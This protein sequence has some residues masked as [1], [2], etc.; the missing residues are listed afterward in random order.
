M[1][2]MKKFQ[3]LLEK[4]F[5]FDAADLDFGVYRILNAKKDRLEKFIREDLKNRVEA[6]FAKHKEERLANIEQN[7]E[8]ATQKVIQGL[9]A[10][11]LPA[12]NNA[13]GSLAG[14]L[15]SRLEACPTKEEFKNTPLGR[16][17]LAIKEQKIEAQKIDEIKSQVFNDLFNFFFRFYAE[18]DFVPQYR[19]SIKGHK[20]AIPYNGEEVK[21]YWANKS[22]YYVKTGLLFR[23]YTFLTDPGKAYKI[24]FRL[25]LAHEELGSN[26]A[27]KE[28]FFVLDDKKPIEN[29]PSPI[30]IIVRFCYRELTAEE[31]KHYQVEGGSNTS[32]QEKINQKTVA[33]VL[34]KI[35]DVTLKGF[36][37]KEYKDEKPLLLYQLL[38]FTAKNTKDYFI[39]QNLKRFLSEQLDYF[40]KAEVL[41]LETLEKEKFLDKHI[42][43]AKVVQ[44]IG[45]DIIDFLAQIED[46]QK[47]LWEKKK[48]VLKTEYVI[49]CDRVPEEF[50]QEILQNEEQKREWVEMGFD[51]PETKEELK[52]KKL[53]IDTRYFTQEFKEKLLEKITEEA[54]LDELLDGLLIKSENWQALNLLMGKYREKI[55]TI[56]IDPPFN[57]GTNA[58][59]LYNVNYKDSSWISILENRLQLAR[60][61]LD[62]KGSI[63]VRCDYNGNMFVRLLLNYIFGE[64]N[65]RNE[66]VINKSIR[67]KTE[68]NKYPT[69]HDLFFYYSKNFENVYFKHITKTREKEEWRSIDTEGESWDIVPVELLHLFSPENLK[70]DEKGRA[71][72]RARIILGQEILPREG[73]RYPSQKT[74]NELERQNRI[75]LASSGNPQMLKPSEI[76]LTDNWSDIY[77][78][79]SNWDFQTENSEIT[80]KRVIESTSNTPSANADTPLK[81]GNRDIVMDF[82]LGSGTTTAVAHKLGRKWIGVEMGEHFW[83]VVLPRMKKVLAYDKSGV[84]KEKDVKEKYN[85]KTTGGFFKYH[86]LEQYEDAL[87]NIELTS[88]KQAELKLG[89]D[90]L[91]KYFLDYE[92]RGNPCLLNMEQLKNPFSYKLKVNLEEVGEPQEIMVDIPETF[93]YLLGL[94][95]KRMKVKYSPLSK[96]VAD[97]RSDGVS[98]KLPYNPNLKEKARELRKSGNLSEVLLWNKLKNRQMLGFDFTR[99]QIIGDYIV[100]FHCPKLNLVIEID[101]ESHDFKGAYDEKRDEF[102]KSLGLEVLHFKDIDVKKLLD[103]VLK[104]IEFWIKGNTPSADADTPLE[105]GNKYLFVLGEKESKDI[106]VV[107]RE[108]N[109]NWSDDDFKKDKEFIV[110]EIE[111][112]APHVVYVNGQSVLTPKLG[113][114]LIEVRY[115]EP[116]FKKLMG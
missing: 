17:Y 12:R 57:L 49:T 41:S 29:I 111:P 108:Y 1:D 11:A 13:G 23:D 47:R 109:D 93:N 15:S 59:F 94:K 91:L 60:I 50:Y 22:S 80:L 64:D 8:E 78:Y 96:G 66:I 37:T 38:R 71:I 98:K 107:W 113:K 20:Y 19:Y 10:Q 9:G 99:Q 62:D 76:Y 67:I 68:G 42:T 32:K 103:N 104:Q 26:K 112:W 33:E 21:L 74:I 110:K 28:R 53:P 100:D 34:S 54:N 97:R 82:F 63:F 101:G 58:D 79:S 72:S 18:G 114:H 45:E 56:Y 84:S 2:T 51:V 115:I 30:A 48:F 25:V 52:K 73:R 92:T 61:M 24:I 46:F 106:A 3:D 83:T 85:E 90:Y 16:E 27:T 65:F 116:E 6:A 77:G 81:E 55:Q 69:W 31:V 102:L 88:N 35:D 40:I 70:Y 87:D 5:Q 89:D 75:R 105:K 43:R 7:Y 36:L 95:V 86:V 4:L 14:E 44:E 39:H